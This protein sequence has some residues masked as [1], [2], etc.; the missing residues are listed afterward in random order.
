MEQEDYGSKSCAVLSYK[1]S[2]QPDT[3]AQRT[4]TQSIILSV[5][6]HFNIDLGGRVS[7]FILLVR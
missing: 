6:F 5:C 7:Y 3:R 1:L 4:L 2:P